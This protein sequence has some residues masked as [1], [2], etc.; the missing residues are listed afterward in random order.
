MG[1]NADAAKAQDLSSPLGKLLRFNDDGGIPA[2]N[3]FYSSQQGLARAVWAYGLR[4]PFSFAVQRSTGRIHIN[5]AG[6]NTWEEIN[7][8]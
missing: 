6:A 8:G 5:D 1:E 7:V 4:N 3:P 2:D